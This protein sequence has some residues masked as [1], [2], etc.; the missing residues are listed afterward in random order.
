[1]RGSSRITD[2]ALQAVIIM[3][4]RHTICYVPYPVHAYTLTMPAGICALFHLES[5][6]DVYGWYAQ[7]Q[8]QHY[9]AGFF[10]IEN[11][12]AD[13]ATRLYRSVGD[14]MQGRWRRETPTPADDLRCPVEE[15]LRHE[16]ERLQSAFISEWLFF[17]ADPQ[18]RQEVEQYQARSLPL[19][20]FN[21]Q[22]RRLNQ[23]DD[24]QP[25]WRHQSRGCDNN[26]LHYLQQCWPF[27]GQELFLWPQPAPLPR[28]RRYDELDIPSMKKGRP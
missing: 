26:I 17:P 3:Q 27:A 14:G 4:A 12:Y 18:H 8:Q 25:I 13:H 21:V 16:L 2:D 6:A 7:A 19:H 9:D 15:E 28:F 23:L 1:M 11:F 24:S 5:R 10:M 22:S 20:A